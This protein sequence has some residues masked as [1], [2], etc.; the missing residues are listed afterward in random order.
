MEKQQ[1]TPGEDDSK[2]FQAFIEWAATHQDLN[3]MTKEEL[4]QRVIYLESE[5]Q[6]LM[7]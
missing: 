5:I 2:S 1:F 6:S 4:I 7:D 3:L